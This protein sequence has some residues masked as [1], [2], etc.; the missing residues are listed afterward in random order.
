[1]DHCQL[2]VADTGQVCLPF[3][4]WHVGVTRECGQ[5]GRTALLFSAPL[6]QMRTIQSS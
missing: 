5:S 3:A 4:G 2:L 6:T 1:M